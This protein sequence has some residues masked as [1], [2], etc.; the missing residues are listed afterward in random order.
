MEPAPAERVAAPPPRPPRKRKKRRTGLIVTLLIAVLVVGTVIVVMMSSSSSKDGIPVE[1]VVVSKRSIVQTVTATGVIDPETQV[2]ISSEVSGEIVFIGVEEGESVKKGQLLVRINPESITAQVDEARAGILGAR[3]RESQA[4]ASLL[5]NQQD[6][7]RIQQL[8]ERKLATQQE[9]DAANASVSISKAELEGAQYSTRQAEAGLRRIRES[10]ART[11]I[12]APISGVVTKLNSKVGEK[13]VG[14]IQMTGTEIMTIADL[15]VIEAV[16]DV[17]ET[18]VVSVSLGDTAEVEVDAMPA[19]KFVAF[20]SRIANSPKQTGVGSQDQVTNFEVRVRFVDP[21][22]RLRPGMT[23]TSTIRVAS[24]SDV[25]AVPIQSVTTRDTTDRK[26]EEEEDD[27][28]RNRAVERAQELRDERPKPV[29]F[30]RQGDSVRMVTVNTGIRDNEFIE[31][32]SGLK[33]GERVVSGT[34]KAIA[35]DLEDK[36]AVI[37]A[38]REEPKGR[39][40]E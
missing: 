7:V 22:T 9:L 3:S 30:V 40:K 15:S 1:T 4:K 13:V 5:R 27:V 23:A 37:D 26:T 34:Y 32:V 25:L 21:D 19:R 18:D 35:K 29:V 24:K 6:L 38:P 20:V 14:A 11:S 10:L 8:F 2:K 33:G 28:A 17:S 36:S 31:I 39:N 12:Y 16:V